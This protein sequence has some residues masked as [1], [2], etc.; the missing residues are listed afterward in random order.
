[1]REF[2]REGQ[3][4]KHLR[5]YTNI[6]ALIYLLREQ[7]ITL[8]DPASWDDKNDS[9]FLSLYREK[10]DL[11]SVLALCFTPAAETYHHWRVFADGS[12]GACIS[13]NGDKLLKAVKKQLGVRAKAVTYLKLSDIRNKPVKIGDL[14]FL[15]RWAYGDEREFRIIYESSDKKSN[16]LDIAIPIA[17]IER[18]TLSP[19][20]PAAL[21]D[22][23]K[24]T[25]KGIKGCSSIKV[26]RST[27]ISNENWKALGDS[28]RN[29]RRILSL[30]RK[31]VGERSGARG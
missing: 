12:S 11:E 9:Y 5:R 2:Q 3:N 22:H 8:L 10:H 21:S 24:R 6:P 31:R 1:M 25:I 26:V 13:F 19:W 17:C 28:A 29:D 14:P 16:S 30:P 4:V 23:V 27:L 20:I 7:K 18:I 15:K